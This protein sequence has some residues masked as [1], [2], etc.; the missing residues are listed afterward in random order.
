MPNITITNGTTTVTMPRTKQIA[1]AGAVVAKESQMASG[2]IVRDVVGFRRGII[3]TW[4]YVPATTIASLKTL[5]QSGGFLTVTYFD[6]D[7]TSH[8][9]LCAVSYPTM[10]VF[11]YKDNVP[12]WHNCSLTIQ[13]QEV[14]T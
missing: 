14:A 8:T 9:E 12:V 1:D 7:G 3:A 5:L 13:A 10:E 11:C 4:D 6:I 2:L